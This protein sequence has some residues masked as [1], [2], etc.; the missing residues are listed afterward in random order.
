MREAARVWGNIRYGTDI[1]RDDDDARL[2]RSWAWD[3]ETNAHVSQ[4]T[5]FSKLVQRKVYE[6]GRSQG[7][8]WVK[9]DERDLRELTNKQ[10]AIGE[11]NCLG[12][13][14]PEDMVQDALAV[15]KETEA[16]YAVNDPV[17]AREKIIRAFSQINISAEMLEQKLGHLLAQ[18]TADEIVELRGIYKSIADGNSSW[19]EYMEPRE[20]REPESGKLS[21]ADMKP[22]VDE[23][24]KGEQQRSRS[25]ARADGGNPDYS[26]GAD[27]DPGP[28]ARQ[29]GEEG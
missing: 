7:T 27:P 5:A 24:P 18:C 2:I 21:M 8:K 3:L 20:R 1:V 15:C 28:A 4:E 25:K 26:E 19:A 10:A 9:P 12:K 6:N 16:R 23:K 11:R 29:P 13:V 22:A 14:L 17:K